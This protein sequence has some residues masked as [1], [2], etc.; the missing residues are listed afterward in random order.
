MLHQQLAPALEQVGERA[1]SLWRIEDIVLLYAFPRQRASCLSDLVTQVRQFLFAC[2]QLFA[3]GNPLVTGHDGMVPCVYLG[4]CGIHG[5]LLKCCLT[6]LTIALHWF[7]Q[8][9]YSRHLWAAA[10]YPA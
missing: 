10:R 5:V 4:S 9:R 8:L 2:E 3:L 6:G 7:S 1:A